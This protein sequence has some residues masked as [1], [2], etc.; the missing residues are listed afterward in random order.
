[1]ERER[2]KI[3]TMREGREYVRKL[4]MYK[5]MKRKNAQERIKAI[6][7]KKQ[8]YRGEIVFEPD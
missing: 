1:M 6:K 3:K 8:R 4:D 2:R 7:A 5:N